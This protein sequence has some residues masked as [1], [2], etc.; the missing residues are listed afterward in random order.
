MVEAQFP[1]GPKLYHRNP[2]AIR[3]GQYRCAFVYESDGKSNVATCDSFLRKRLDVHPGLEV[4]EIDPV[5]EV[6]ANKI[7]GPIIQG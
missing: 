1:I 7:T 2:S 3:T 4:I 6:G 5:E